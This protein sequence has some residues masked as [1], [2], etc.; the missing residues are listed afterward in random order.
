M[1][2]STDLPGIF[3]FVMPFASLASVKHAGK[4]VD[5][6]LSNARILFV[7]CDRRV[8]LS[9]YPAHVQHLPLISLHYL[10]ELT[11]RIWSL[12]LWLVKLAAI[13]FTASLEFLLVSSRVDVVICFLGAYYT[14]V[15]ILA[16]LLN[17]K[18]LCF[19]P[20]GEMAAAG[21]VYQTKW[22]GEKLISALRLLTW[23]N[24]SLADLIVIESAEV[25]REGRLEPYLD[26]LRIANLYIDTSK[27]TENISLDS[28]GR[29]VGFLGRLSAEKGILNLLDAAQIM[30]STG[31]NFMIAGDGP[32]RKDVEKLL[33]APDLAH[34]KYL[35]WLGPEEITKF[36]N[37]IRIFILPSAGEGIPNSALEAMACGTPVLATPVGGLNELIVE[38][39]TGYFISDP[40]PAGLA[41]S[42]LCTLSDPNLAAVA[43]KGKEFVN[44]NYSLSASSR[45]WRRVLSEFRTKI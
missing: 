20:V 27:Y 2:S 30:Y 21:Q 36:M 31:I 5:C 11:P 16:K 17:K 19:E 18:V 3:C 29:A 23:I 15:L 37:G 8:N 28:R 41:R 45:K 7:A 38:S 24:R 1:E 14:P 33:E 44:S 22:G 34:A 9:G 43:L 10:V 12:I 4:L 6:L 13:L 42:I 26:K 25:I 40:T 35:G 32:L 39:E